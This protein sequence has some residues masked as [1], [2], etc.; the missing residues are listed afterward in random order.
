MAHQAPDH[1]WEVSHIGGDRF[2]ANALVL[3]HGLYY[4]GLEPE[5]A[6]PFVETHATG[7][8][9]LH[10]L[11]GRTAYAFPVQAAEIYLRRHLGLAEVEPLGVVGHDREGSRH[12]VDLVA[13]GR[14]WRVEVETTVGEQRQLTCTATRPGRALQHRLLGLHPVEPT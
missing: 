9:D 10:H 7:R 4:G 11:R 2:A 8:L 1:V 13:A 5:D 6:Q 14:R 3:P 12:Q